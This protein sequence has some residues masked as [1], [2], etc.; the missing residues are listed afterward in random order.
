MIAFAQS[1]RVCLPQVRTI[2]FL[3]P[4]ARVAR[5]LWRPSARPV[6]DP[7]RRD[8]ARLDR[9]HSA[10]PSTIV[11]CRSRRSAIWTLSSR[12]RPATR[13]RTSRLPSRRS[14]RSSSP[15]TAGTARHERP[16]APSP[17]PRPPGTQVG[18]GLVG[19]T[20]G[21][22][23]A[24]A[25]RSTAV[26]PDIWGG[27][28]G[29]LGAFMAAIY[30]TIQSSVEQMIKSYPSGLKEAFGA[31]A[32]NTVE[33]YV[34]AELFSLIVPL[35]IGYYA[36]RTVATPLVGAEERGHLDT[37]FAA[38]PQDGA[39]GRLV[40]RGRS[41]LC[42]D[43]GC[44]RRRDV[45]RRAPCRDWYLAWVGGRRR[46]GRVPAGPV[47]W[48]FA[49]VAS[50]ATARLDGRQRRR[51]RNARRDVRPRPRRAPRACP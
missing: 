3:V 48:R 49:A 11:A 24:R 39:R 37:I 7:V 16:G 33:G 26:H 31:G 36:V 46:R 13:S 6:S 47:R 28:L 21:G 4:P 45:R 51:D 1:R 35:A 12:R 15:S 17:K 20:V 38:A 5:S 18:A 40:C 23:P 9:R 14:R 42:R 34:H 43:P 27:S 41:E 44:A 25:A 19:G 29:V 10:R 50:G 32:M 22:R 30:P 2:A 8:A